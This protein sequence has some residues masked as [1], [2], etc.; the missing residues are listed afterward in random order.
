MNLRFCYVFLTFFRRHNRF[1]LNVY[2]QMDIN[3]EQMQTTNSIEGSNNFAE[4]F[5]RCYDN[6]LI[7]IVMNRNNRNLEPC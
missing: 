4:G 2:I 3:L 5:Q 7:G 6:M 1:L